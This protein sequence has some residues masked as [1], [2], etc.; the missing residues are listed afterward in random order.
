MVGPRQPGGQELLHG[1]L[2]AGVEEGPHPKVRMGAAELGL[3]GLKVRLQARRDLERG[4]IDLEKAAAGEEGAKGT[5]DP[6]PAFQERTLASVHVGAP[7]RGATG[8]AGH[9]TNAPSPEARRGKAATRPAGGRRDG[10]ASI[11]SLLVAPPR[12]C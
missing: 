6:R 5:G 2:R 11:G 10:N 7:P 4:R 9:G 12:S 1:E 3:E 8:A